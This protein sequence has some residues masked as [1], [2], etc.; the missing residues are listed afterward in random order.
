M[1]KGTADNEIVKQLEWQ[2]DKLVF[3]LYGLNRE[4]ILIIDREFYQLNS[5]L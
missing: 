5:C 2:I 4:E 3:E 1:K